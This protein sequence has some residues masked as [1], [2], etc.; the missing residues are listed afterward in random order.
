MLSY[1][2]GYHAGGFA[3]VIKHV[4]LV[5][6]CA[7][8]IKKAKP[9]FYLETHA[10]RGLYDLQS[11]QALKTGE[12]QAGIGSLWSDRARLPAEFAPYI[13]RCEG[14][15]PSGTLRFYPGSPLIARDTLRNIDR[16][17]LCELHPQEFSAL[18]QMK[19]A[20]K[21]LS[22]TQTNGLQHL[23]AVLPP[24]E[25]RGLIFIDPAYEVKRDYED[26]PRALKIAYQR[27]PQGVYCVW[28]PILDQ[29]WHTQL[30]RRLG[31]IGERPRLRVELNL[32]LSHAAGMQACGLWI[33]NPPYVLA[34]ELHRV[35]TTLTHH[36][37]PGT[38]NFLVESV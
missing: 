4:T 9:L 31:S 30:L 24:P 33:I 35:L 17:T 36:W 23:S 21:R 5:R 26:L 29:Q 14:L 1:Q 8:L 10:G 22:V 7:Y 19:R 28:Y 3:D 25:R 15:N 18:E 2:H 37:Q 13:Q 34:E 20:G 27:F 12:A 32:G 38:S 6:L 11:T 16:L